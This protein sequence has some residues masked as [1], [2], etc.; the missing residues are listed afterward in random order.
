MATFRAGLALIVSAL[1]YDL[2]FGK[3]F[4]AGYPLGTVRF[5]MSG[6]IHSHILPNEAC[7]ERISVK[8]VKLLELS[9][10]ALAQSPQKW[11]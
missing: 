7:L 2:G 6:T 9:P 3:I 8:T 1:T 4:K 10:V 5:I 11:K